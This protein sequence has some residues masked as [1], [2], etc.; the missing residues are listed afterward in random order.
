MTEWWRPTFQTTVD[1]FYRGEIAAGRTACEQL[2]S[3][4]G[5]PADVEAQTHRNMMFY[6]SR[7]EE[8]A[9][10]T[11]MRRIEVPVQAGW[12][13]FNPSIA[14]DG[15]GFRMILRSSN[16]AYVGQAMTMVVL[17]PE[18]VVRT[19][20]YL[21]ELDADLDIGAVTPIDDCQLRPDPP[22][23]PVAGFEDYRLIPGA[24]RWW[25]SAAVRDRTPYGLI[26][27]VLVALDGARAGDLRVISDSPRRHEKNWMPV[28]D[29]PEEAVRFVYSAA[30]TVVVR[31]DLDT[32]ELT[33]EVIREAPPIASRARGGSQVVAIDDGW[34]CLTHEVGFSRQGVRTYAHRWLWFDTAWRLSRISAPFMFRERG[35]EFAA[36]LARRGD[37]L[38]VS[39]GVWDREAWLAT[40]PGAEVLALLAPPLD[41]AAVE[42]EIR[43][44]AVATPAV[45]PVV[46][47]VTIVSMTLAGNS[48][49]IIGDAI[50]SVVDWVD[51]VL[52]IDTGITDDT[53]DVARTVAGDKLVVRQFPWCDDFAAARN[54]ALEAAAETGATWAV[55]IDT[56]ERLLGGSRAVREVLAT[57]S[58]DS[59]H[60][61]FSDGSYGKERFFRL[62]ARGRYIGPT[63]EAFMRSHGGP[64]VLEAIFFDELP[65]SAEQYRQ[66]AERDVAI[67]AQH[68]SQ[69]PADPRWFYYLGDSLA[70]LDRCEEAIA[71]FRRCWELRGWDEEGAW[72][73]YRAAQCHLALGRFDDA[74]EACALGMTRHAG[75]GELTWLAAYASWRAGRP[76]QAA[77]WAGQSVAMGRF[78]GSGEMVTR[79]GF[80]YPV[81]LWEGPYD[82]LRYALREIGEEAS[83]NE[84]ERLYHEAKTARE[85]QERGG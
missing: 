23:F 7:L 67:L 40:V 17:D 62:P 28:L 16:Y 72:A 32:A 42:A 5:L 56:D 12:S 15:D 10:S 25:A 6:L 76:E 43:A 61:R 84:A 38:I 9:L 59:L 24:R 80:R 31:Y 44:S 11:T 54:F 55:T 30:P 65:K 19:E 66:K 74:V 45:A 52:V 69:N 8:M 20:S 27:T 64:Q 79:I 26:Q 29:Q 14:A 73:M 13:Q 35:V 1:A 18:K 60:V 83:A 81:A 46:G 51:H 78:A 63:H 53:L 2:L 21:V 47:D 4:R 58:A 50:A 48:A 68:T 85:R 70:G 37:D 75:L 34:L 82:V 71:A 36:G 49:A 39:F 41:A 33:P 3:L 77:Y 57:A 22:L